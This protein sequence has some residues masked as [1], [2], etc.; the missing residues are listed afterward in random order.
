VVAT[1]RALRAA[2]VTALE[3][4]CARRD[5]AAV[6][7]IAAIERIVR[8][9]ADPAAT[10]VRVVE[11][12][13]DALVAASLLTELPARRGAVKRLGGAGGARRVGLG[14]AALERAPTHCHAR[15]RI[16]EE[17]DTGV[18]PAPPDRA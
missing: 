11:L 2:L 13:E 17:A 7:A 4:A 9:A 1:D 14:R 6:E 3:P 18:P 15:T 5:A 10:A 8:T 16:S 12:G